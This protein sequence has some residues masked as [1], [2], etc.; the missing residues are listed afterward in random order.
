MPDFVPGLE[1][2]HIFYVEAV[3]P[4][5]DREFPDLPYSAALIGVGS[6][7]LGFDTEMSRDHH[8]GPRVMLFVRDEDAYPR[9]AIDEM[10]RQ[11]LPY[12][13]RGHSTHFEASY[14][15]GDRGTPV[16]KSL[17]QG[18]VNHLVE[19]MGIREYF[20][21]YLGFD[22][23]MELDAI[24]WLTLPQQKLRTVTA[25]AVYHDGIGLGAVRERFS[26]YPH[27][28][29]LY[30]LLS[31]WTRLGQEE[32]LAPRAGYVGDEL[33]SAI[34]AGRL[35]RD[36]MNLCFLMEKTYAPY[37]KWFG[38]AFAQLDCA[39]ELTPI[40]RKV[41]RGETWQERERH[42]CQAYEITAQMHNALGITKK[43]PAK[44]SSFHDRPFKVIHSWRFE[45]AIREEIRDPLLKEI[46][47]KR[48]I[49]S[50]DQ[51]SDNVDLR[52]SSTLRI[53]LRA[54]YGDKLPRPA[55]FEV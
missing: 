35:V 48:C 51:F 30:L 40:L 41:Q 12:W 24:D 21:Q 33:G 55:S 42:L 44:V 9:E 45:E 11:N 32:H 26:Y 4:I 46:S 47:S 18:P 2:N 16:S 20:Q 29:W 36:I 28:V 3:K 7:V 53:E 54:L 49:G 5:L 23:D 38:T 19:I 13:V 43:I 14:S 34:I 15:E 25:G 50:I 31:G 27:D 10:L 37:A 22:I 8:W 6:E 39:A 1:L 52:S 17:E